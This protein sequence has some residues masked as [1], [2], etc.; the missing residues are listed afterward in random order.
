MRWTDFFKV[1]SGGAAGAGLAIAGRWG[2]LLETS[3]NVRTS[4][5][6]EWTKPDGRSTVALTPDFGT[7][8]IRLSDKVIS[9][10]LGTYAGT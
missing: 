10:I 5:S 3:I 6:L 7:Y 4:I 8:W 9:V 2:T 1:V